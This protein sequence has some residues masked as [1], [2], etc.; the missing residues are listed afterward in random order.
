MGLAVIALLT[1]LLY[2]E[3]SKPQVDVDA[4]LDRAEEAIDAK[5]FL[6]ART[7]LARA[8]RVGELDADDEERAMGL[9]ARLEQRRSVEEARL[10][11]EGGDLQTARVTLMKLLSEVPGDPEGRALMTEL[12]AR[13]SGAVPASASAAPATA[14]AAP[15]TAPAAPATAPA[16]PAAVAPAAPAPAVPAPP[17]PTPVAAP[18]VPAAPAAVLPGPPPPPP[19]VAARPPSGSPR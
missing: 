15:A 6:L 5:N 7:A 14:P 19:S 13:L 18:A 10:A 2:V 4:L 9:Q 3:V 8:E 12:Q 16:A 1:A 11:L 17:A